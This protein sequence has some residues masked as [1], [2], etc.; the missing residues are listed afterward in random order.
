MSD[1]AFKREEDKLRKQLKELEETRK[2]LSTLRTLESYSV[3][4]KCKRFDEIFKLA[5]ELFDYK[6][7]EGYEMK[8][9]DHWCFEM[10][11]ELLGT[12]V[13]DVYSKLGE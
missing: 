13:W 7:K 2:K 11:L 10:V 9:A 8:D 12:N 6:S 1:E 4:E 5:K 3:K